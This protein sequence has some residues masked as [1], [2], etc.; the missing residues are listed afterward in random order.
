[1]D[2]YSVVELIWRRDDPGGRAKKTGAVM[3]HEW[4]STG[5]YVK[6]WCGGPAGRLVRFQ[7]D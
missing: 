5:L 3:G 2:P 1:L 4:S 6:Q 7:I